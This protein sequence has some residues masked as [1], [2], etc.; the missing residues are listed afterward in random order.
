MDNLLEA[1]Q[2][3]S[4][5]SEPHRPLRSSSPAGTTGAFPRRKENAEGVLSIDITGTR[6][7]SG[8]T[9]LLYYIV[10]I[11]VLPRSYD[12]VNINGKETAL[13]VIDCE[14]R[15][16]VQRL[17]QIIA[18]HISSAESRRHLK[19]SDIDHIVRT[20]LDHVHLYRPQS[21]HS[22]IATIPNISSYLLSRLAH[23]SG[24]RPLGSIILDG[25][26]SFLWK[27]RADEEISRFSDEQTK[28]DRPIVDANG[29]YAD[30]I[31]RLKTFALQFGCPVL[32]TSWSHLSLSAET[33]NVT[34][35]SMMPPSWN[36]FAK[37]RLE[38]RRVPIRPFPPMMS[39]EEILAEKAKRAD[40][41]RRGEFEVSVLS[42]SIS[43]TFR[44]TIRED[45]V[46]I[47][48]HWEESE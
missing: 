22:A 14:D 38:V 42:P 12:G 27:S 23:K 24:S 45:G 46:E 28:R 40:F 33:G 31:Q 15:F 5:R 20:S 18:S 32:T 1:L 25:A 4:T 21:I 30:L 8:K 44:F 36:S 11:A 43:Q 7:G 6:P 26:G 47:K 29:L 2:A 35:R 19:E 39:L 3:D 48:N 34:T 13:V 37:L 17:A 9:H 41:A 16:N 10:T